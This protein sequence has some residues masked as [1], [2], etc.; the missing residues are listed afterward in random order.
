MVSGAYSGGGDP[1]RSL[2][3]LW[4]ARDR[5]RA[6]RGGRRD[7]TLD[8]VVRAAIE[9]AD[10]EGLVALSMRRVAD[11]LGVGTMSL[12]T[13]VPGKAE[14]IDLMLDTTYGELVREDVAGNWRA[15][16]EAVARQNWQLYRRHPWM[17]TVGMSRP[18][19]GPHVM[20]KY[21]YELRTVADPGL[22]ELEMDSVLN[23]VLGHAEVAARRASDASATESETGITDD[24]W[25]QKSGPMLAALVDFRQFPTAS[26]VGEAVGNALGT[27]YD[28]EHNFEFGLRRILDGIEA[29]VRRRGA[30]GG[31]AG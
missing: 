26:R 14:L 25:W 4:G 3:L 12:Y 19:L 15:R 24:Q 28:P 10:K 6:G 30:E 29:L 5:P 11:A 20:A 31:A 7:L 27:A 16:L 1:A 18:P 13:Y 17:L 23:L 22:D 8:R 9:V 2:G 21:E